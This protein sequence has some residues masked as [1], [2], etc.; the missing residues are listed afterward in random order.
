[1]VSGPLL[2]FDPSLPPNKKSQS[3]RAD[4]STSPACQEGDIISG[5]G[6][7]RISPA[8]GMIAELTREHEEDR[9][10]DS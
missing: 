5:A 4:I 9:A 1:M 7:Y 3:F 10:V 6:G 2:R 8:I